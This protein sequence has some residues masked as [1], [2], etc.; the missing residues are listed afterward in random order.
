MEGGGPGTGSLADLL[1][2]HRGV[3][4]VLSD[5]MGETLPAQAPMV[6]Q[7]GATLLRGCDGCIEDETLVGEAFHQVRGK[8]EVDGNGNTED[9]VRL[10]N[11]G[12]PR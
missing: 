1:D 7:E 12:S 8:S 9:L 3:G 2:V 11:N 6:S 5:P 10:S 4:G